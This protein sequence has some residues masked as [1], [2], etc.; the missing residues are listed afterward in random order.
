MIKVETQ[1]DINL[2]EYFMGLSMATKNQDMIPVLH[3]LRLSI[4][5]QAE[6]L[7]K[8]QENKDVVEKVVKDIA[9]EAK[10]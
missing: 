2:I 4:I 3:S 7:T 5:A 6:Q 10:K 9:K 1:E 8:A